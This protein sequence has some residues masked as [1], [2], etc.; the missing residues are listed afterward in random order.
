MMSITEYSDYREV[1]GILIPFSQKVTLGPQILLFDAKE[2]LV[3]SGV[4]KY[5]TLY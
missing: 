5:R 1:D 4:I 2:V 3:N